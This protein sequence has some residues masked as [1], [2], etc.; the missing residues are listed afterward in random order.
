VLPWTESPKFKCSDFLSLYV[1]VQRLDWF[2]L[3]LQQCKIH[4]RF[5]STACPCNCVQ[6]LPTLFAASRPCSLPAGRDTTIISQQRWPID[7]KDTSYCRRTI[8]DV[9]STDHSWTR[10]VIC[11]CSRRL[12]LQGH[13]RLQQCHQMAHLCC[14]RTR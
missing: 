5:I 14:P 1:T 10:R 11:V 7:T 8:D 12:V 6:I 3:D 13:S 2:S 9:G 4:Q